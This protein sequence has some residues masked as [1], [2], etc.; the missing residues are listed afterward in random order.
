MAGVE[1]R[2]AVRVRRHDVRHQRAALLPRLRALERDELRGGERCAGLRQRL[3][4]RQAGGHRREDVAAVERRRHRLEAPRRRGDLDRLRDAAEALGRGHEEAVVGAHEQPVLLLGAQRDRP[5]LRAHL[6]IDHRQVH[7]RG[8]VR[9]GAL[10]HPRSRLHV[11]PRDAV[12]EVDHPRVRRRRGDDAV[13]DADEL[14]GQP[15]VGEERDRER[16]RSASSASTSPS[17]VW[18]SASRCGSVPC[19]RSAALVAGPIE[20]S[21]GPS[22][23]PSPAASAKKRTEEAEVKSR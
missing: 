9:Q 15:V 2:V 23:A 18:G 13:D 22:R 6:G 1:D 20:A 16:H 19:S 14:V 3:P 8:R 5:A 12:A 17:G 11:L 21:R 7:A 10:E 4:A